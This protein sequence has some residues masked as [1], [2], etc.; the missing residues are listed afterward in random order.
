[1]KYIIV[2]GNQ[3]IFDANLK[4]LLQGH[5]FRLSVYSNHVQ[6]MYDRSVAVQNCVNELIEHKL[7]LSAPSRLSFIVYQ[8][9]NATFL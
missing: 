8:H 5:S 1:M 7:T 9:L 2:S 4:E 3:L 6:L